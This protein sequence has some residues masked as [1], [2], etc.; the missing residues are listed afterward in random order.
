MLRVFLNRQ[1]EIGG[2]EGCL[3]LKLMNFIFWGRTFQNLSLEFECGKVD[4]DNFVE[5]H[6]N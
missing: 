3:V 5:D 6:T 1:E 4:Q 2:A